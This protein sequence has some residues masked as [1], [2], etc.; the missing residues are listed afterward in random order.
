MYDGGAIVKPVR[1]LHHHYFCQM[2]KIN[3]KMLFHLILIIQLFGCS[4][5]ESVVPSVFVSGAETNLSI[6]IV[7]YWKN[8]IQFNLSN[9]S[10]SAETTSI[11][12]S[13]NDVYVCGNQIATNSGNS[14]A[15]YW[16]NGVATFLTNGSSPLFASANSIFVDGNDVYVAGE[17][18]DDPNPVALFWKMAYPTN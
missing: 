11:F 2:E 13:G 17:E 8:G 12:I 4:K 14:A 18:T 10:V 15:K 7:K 3:P 16:K 6:W 9:G 5:I 1:L